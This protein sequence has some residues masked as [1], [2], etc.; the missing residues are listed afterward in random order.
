MPDGLRSIYYS[1]IV[2]TTSVVQSGPNFGG[3][4][5]RYGFVEAGRGGRQLSI[6]VLIVLSAMSLASWFFMLTSVGPAHDREGV[7]AGAEEVLGLGQSVD[8][9]P[10]CPA[11]TTSSE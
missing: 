1:V 10:R 8:G 9:R 11:A 2:T 4:H 3:S 5:G 6:A 7:R